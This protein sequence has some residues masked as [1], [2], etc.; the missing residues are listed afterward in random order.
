MSKLQ[1]EYDDLWNKLIGDSVK[2]YPSGGSLVGTGILF[3]GYVD[4]YDDL[5]DTLDIPVYENCNLQKVSNDSQI[6]D[7]IIKILKV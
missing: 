5:V 6:P 3:I 7:T 4:K 1:D 2:S